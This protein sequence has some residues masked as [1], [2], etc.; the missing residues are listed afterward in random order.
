[1]TLSRKEQEIEARKKDI[2]EIAAELFAQKDF[3]G[4]TMDEIAEKV[5]LS[6]GTVYLY[7]ETKENLFFSILID[8]TKSLMLSLKDTIQSEVS[9]EAS[10]RDFVFTFLTYFQ[11]H[12]AYFKLMHSEK[13]RASMDAHYQM[14]DYAKEIFNQ[15]NDILAELIKKGVADHCLR[16][17]DIFSMVKMLGGILNNFTYYQIFISST[18][19]PAGETELIIDLFLNGVKKAEVTEVLHET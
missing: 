18:M 10:L 19:S 5:G 3:H 6:K 15:F 7:F 4:V 8:R 16:S 9:F 11:K 1:M 14:H 2:L 13:T 12:K 17:V